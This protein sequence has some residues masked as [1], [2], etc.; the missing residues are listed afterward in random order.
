LSSLSS[1]TQLP[2]TSYFRPAV[3]FPISTTSWN[4]LSF[5]LTMKD[6]KHMPFVLIFIEHVN[7]DITTNVHSHF[8]G[9]AWHVGGKVKVLLRHWPWE[10]LRH[11]YTKARILVFPRPQ[12]LV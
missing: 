3:R 7:I 12:I 9:F 11:I 4:I 1:V 2:G 6:H 10:I 5:S 8:A